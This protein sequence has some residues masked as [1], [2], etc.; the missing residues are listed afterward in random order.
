MSGIKGMKH[1]PESYK[2]QVRKDYDQGMGIRALSRKYGISK[3]SAARWCSDTFHTP[4]KKGRP[5]TKSLSLEERVEELEREN[6]LL[7]S[8][9]AAAGRK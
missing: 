9:L 3:Y 1:Y 6:E 8:F 5:R 7:R 2:K 4:K